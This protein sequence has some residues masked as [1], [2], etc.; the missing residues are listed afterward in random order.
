MS[1]WQVVTLPRNRREH[2]LKRLN[3]FLWIAVG[4][5]LL[6]IRMR[7]KKGNSSGRVKAIPAVQGGY[8]P[9][10]VRGRWG[11][12]IQITY[13]H[14]FSNTIIKSACTT[15]SKSRNTTISKFVFSFSLSWR[16]V[17][18]SWWYI[19]MKNLAA[20]SSPGISHDVFLTFL[21]LWLKCCL[22]AI[23]WLYRRERKIQG[24]LFLLSFFCQTSCQT[25]TT[26]SVASFNIPSVYCHLS[27]H[28]FDLSAHVN[29]IFVKYDV[30]RWRVTQ[31]RTGSTSMFW[32]A[33]TFWDTFR[34]Q[35]TVT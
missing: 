1:S 11:H 31:I 5:F 2:L 19:M 24:Y 32:C 21:M 28:E 29:F 27:Q 18:W 16:R 9:P 30:N 4:M 20:S 14:L 10:F 34:P 22:H 12:E 25:R 7:W 33:L 6:T 8:D 35:T 3:H 15:V 23:H 26:V 13:F 17:P